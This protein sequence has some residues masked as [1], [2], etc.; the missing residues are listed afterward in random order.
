MQVEQMRVNHNVPR[1]T[2][3]K[4]LNTIF[5]NP[6][7]RRADQIGKMGLS[8]T[9]SEIRELLGDFIYEGVVSEVK[10]DSGEWCYKVSPDDKQEARDE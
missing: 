7:L 6:M 8:R 4:I 10:N 2:S 5:D 1:S 3:E 9:K